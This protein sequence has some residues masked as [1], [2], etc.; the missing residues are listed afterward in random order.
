VRPILA[1]S[2]PLKAR[3]PVRGFFNDMRGSG[4]GDGVRLRGRKKALKGE[5]QERIRHE[6]RP[7]GTGRI[8]ASR[9]RE[10]PRTQVTG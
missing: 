4:A 6:T 3:R 1:W 9:G 5:P 8:K 10:N 2:K 7:A